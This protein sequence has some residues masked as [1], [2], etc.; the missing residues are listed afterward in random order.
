[1]KNLESVQFEEPSF[2][3]EEL[4]LKEMEE[5]DGGFAILILGGMAVASFA[6]GYYVGSNM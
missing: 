5:I 6:L 3:V 2:H 4:S 1:M